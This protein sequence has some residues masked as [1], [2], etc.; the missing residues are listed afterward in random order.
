MTT[1]DNQ[2]I[3]DSLIEQEKSFAMWRIPGE[4]IIHFRMQSTGSPCLIHSIEE[5]NKRSGFVIAPFRVNKEHPIVLIEPDC[6]TLPESIDEKEHIREKNKFRPE[7]IQISSERDEKNMY[8]QCFSI[9]TQPLLN[10][11]LDKLVLSRSR[12]INRNE[13]FSPGTAFYT[14]VKRY[15]RSYVYLCYTPVTGIWMGST[16]EI[17]L[18]GNNGQWQTVALAGTQPIKNGEIPQKWNDKNWR[19]QQ[20]V[21][22]YIRR[23][24]ASLNISPQE[25]GPYAIRAGEVSHLKSDFKFSLPNKNELGNVLALLHPTPAVCG[26]PKSEAYQFILNNER[27]DRSYYSGFIGWL[28]P[29][30]RT[31]LYVNLR[32]MHIEP[33]NF[34]LYAGG[35]L[36]ASSVLDEEWQETEDKMQTMQRLL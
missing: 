21:A 34:T 9:F 24:L 7:E 36:L 22:F 32:C 14:A 15:I 1:E 10:G 26:L 6:F 17:L 30:D 5:L 3:I 33:D 27:Y 29:H 20:L 13:T 8:A 16:P 31:D 2:K 35:G 19:E 4:D 11:D 12:T 28:D 18:A 25:N 23:Q